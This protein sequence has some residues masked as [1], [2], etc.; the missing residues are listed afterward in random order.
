[1]RY[2]F[3]LFIILYCG[4]VEKGLKAQASIETDSLSRNILT[5]G[6]DLAED[7]LDIVTVEKG[8]HVF[9][10]Y[11]AMGYSPRTGLELGIMPVWRIQAVDGRVKHPTTLSTSLQF[12]LKGMYNVK[13]DLRAFLAKNW[14][15]WSMV[16]YTFLPDVFYGL[17]NAAKQEP[18]SHYD[19]NSLTWSID[20]AKGIGEKWYLGARIDIN[21]NQHDNISGEL[22]NESIDGYEGGW[23]NGIGPMLVFDSRDDV[24]YPTKGSLLMVSHLFYNGDFKFSSSSFDFRKYFTIVEDKSVLAWQAVFKATNGTVPFYKLS[25]IGGKELLRG[26]PHPHKYLDKNAWYSQLEWRQHIWWR[27]GVVGFAGAGKV[28]PDFDG[29]VFTEMHTVAGLGFRFQVLPNDGL[30]FRLDYG[31]SGYNERGLFFTIREAF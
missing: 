11:P 24:L 30:N 15:L 6:A 9:S 8:R 7:M 2:I 14:L 22:L 18:F 19:L 1:M 12:S 17:G 16:Q 5:R 28:M 13:L 27:V 3:I 10:V 4:V 20:L 23:A 31:I 21:T 26:I 25:S 29:N